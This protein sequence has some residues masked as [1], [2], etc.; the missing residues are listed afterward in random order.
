LNF[1]SDARLRNEKDYMGNSQVQKCYEYFYLG[2]KSTSSTSVLPQSSKGFNPE[3]EAA[4]PNQSAEKSGPFQYN[5]VPIE[6]EIEYCPTPPK[7]QMNPKINNRSYNCNQTLFDKKTN[8]KSVNSNISLDNL[9]SNNNFN[10]NF[11]NSN[12]KNQNSNNNYNIG[13]NN[14]KKK[15]ITNENF[16][17]SFNKIL[18]FNEEDTKTKA[19]LANLKIS[20]NNPNFNYTKFYQ[21]QNHFQSNTA[22]SV[23]STSNNLLNAS[24]TDSPLTLPHNSSGSLEVNKQNYYSNLNLIFNE[25]YFQRNPYRNNCINTFSI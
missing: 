2:S 16:S 20:E 12:N 3:E 18:K 24:T 1:P 22:N 9:N 7:Q 25:D 14:N 4:V 21:A 6:E 17:E 13:N 15:L 8:S 5:E 23:D 10:M 19:N 11:T